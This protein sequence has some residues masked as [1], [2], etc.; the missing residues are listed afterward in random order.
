MLQNV[1]PFNDLLEEAKAVLLDIGHFFQVQDDYLDCFGDYE[2]IGKVGTDIAD[3][4]C[5]WLV[6]TALE[7]ASP[8]Q[9]Q[10]IKVYLQI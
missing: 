5:T 4:K 6:V 10:Y 9:R 2:S 3:G 7:M 1:I 8:E